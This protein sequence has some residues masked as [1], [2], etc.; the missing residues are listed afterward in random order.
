M[1]NLLVVFASATAIVFSTL[2]SN[3]Q[4]YL[5][6]LPS[7]GVSGGPY[8]NS[9]YRQYRYN[10]GRESAGWRQQRNDWRDNSNGSVWRRDRNDWKDADDWR[11]RDRRDEGRKDYIKD[12]TKDN[13]KDNVPGDAARETSPQDTAPKGSAAQSTENDDSRAVRPWR[14]DSSSPRSR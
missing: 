2:P 9:D 11:P 7:N 13:T 4:A 3:A 1:R 12:N 6:G 8:G 14:R 10:Q 5:Y